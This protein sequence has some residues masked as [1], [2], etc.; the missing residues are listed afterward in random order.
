MHVR[1]GIVHHM[2]EHMASSIVSPLLKILNM[3]LQ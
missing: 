2:L 1:C 3:E